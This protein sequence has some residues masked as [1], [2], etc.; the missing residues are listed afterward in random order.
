[1]LKN[2]Q[3]SRKIKNILN[4]RCFF[5]L[6]PTQHDFFIFKKAQKRSK[7]VFFETKSVKKNVKMLKI[8]LKMPV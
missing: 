3:K 2:G 4:F 1:M 5:S 7:E 6:L 8:G